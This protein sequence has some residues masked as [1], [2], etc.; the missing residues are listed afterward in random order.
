MKDDENVN[1]E[2]RISATNQ[3]NLN[4][5][6]KNSNLSEESSKKF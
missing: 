5:S 6:L 2:N 1:I 4:E 3:D